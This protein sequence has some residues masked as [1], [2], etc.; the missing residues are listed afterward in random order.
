MAV[1]LILAMWRFAKREGT[2]S[3]IRQENN[4]LKQESVKESSEDKTSNT[5]ATRRDI[6]M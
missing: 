3:L 2:L 1:F 5:K 4:R 6:L